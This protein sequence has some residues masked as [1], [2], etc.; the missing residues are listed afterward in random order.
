MINKLKKYKQYQEQLRQELKAYVQNKNNSLEERWNALI[1]D[2]YLVDKDFRTG[3]GLDRGDSFLYEFPLYM[4][5]Y[6]TRSVTS[7][8]D[9]LKKA[10]EEKKEDEDEYEWELF[11]REEE[12]VFKEYCCNNFISIMVFD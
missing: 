10:N 11:T 12:I 4:Q 2:E 1:E 8:L 3:F 6:E 9:R 5:K 7:I